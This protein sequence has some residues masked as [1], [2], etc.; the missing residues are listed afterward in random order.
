MDCC[1][2][3]QLRQPPRFSRAWGSMDTLQGAASIVRDLSDALSNM[4]PWPLQQP[5]AVLGSDVAGLLGFQP[6][7][8]GIE[9]LAVSPPLYFCWPHTCIKSA[10]S[11]GVS[12]GY[13]PCTGHM[14]PTAPATIPSTGRAGLLPACA[15][16]Q[17]VPA[18]VQS[19]GAD[20]ARPPGRRQLWAGM[21]LSR[22]SACM[23]ASLPLTAIALLQNGIVQQP[24]GAMSACT[25]LR[26]SRGGEV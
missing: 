16:Q 18:Q 23:R 13:A 15:V 1:S 25:Q 17:A 9:R 20:A 12:V 22:I 11:M 5:V 2:L 19:A 3:L 4:L 6:Q 26:L 24:K 7:R 8:D 10:C 21:R 14:V